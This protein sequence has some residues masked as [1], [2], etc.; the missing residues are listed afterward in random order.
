MA[1]TNTPDLEL[2]AASIIA[3]LQTLVG[4]ELHGQVNQPAVTDGLNDHVNTFM[5]D[6]G[7]AFDPINLDDLGKV[8]FWRFGNAVLVLYFGPDDGT[9]KL[10]SGM[11]S[12]DNPATSTLPAATG[13]IR[14]QLTELLT[15]LI[16]EPAIDLEVLT[17]LSVQLGDATFEEV[18]GGSYVFRRGDDRWEHRPIDDDTQIGHGEVRLTFESNRLVAVSAS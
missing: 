7:P 17:A 14:S 3:K 8:E 9:G 2:G 10:W 4:V 13:R 5:A 16:P 6:H 11:L 15:V 12:D 1:T 18:D